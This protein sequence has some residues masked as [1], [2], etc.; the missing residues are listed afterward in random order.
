V[1]CNV[2]ATPGGT[3]TSQYVAI[4]VEETIVIK[5]VRRVLVLVASL[6]GLLALS[7]QAASAGMSL[8]HC[9]PL[10]RH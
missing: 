6:T 2:F 1:R 8:N 7:A 3:L 10:R 4:D 5:Y 9:E